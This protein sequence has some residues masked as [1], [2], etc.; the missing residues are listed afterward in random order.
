MGPPIIDLKFEKDIMDPHIIKEGKN[1]QLQ[2]KKK[3][4]TLC[5]KCLQFGHPKKYCRSNWELYT[6]CKKKRK[7]ERD[8]RRNK[9]TDKLLEPSIRRRD[10]PMKKAEKRK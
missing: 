2:I 7:P 4:L 9:Y 8:R 6:N 1:I 3:R 10:E 5:E